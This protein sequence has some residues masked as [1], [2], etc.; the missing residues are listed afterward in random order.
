MAWLPQSKLLPLQVLLICLLGVLEYKRSRYL[1]IAI[2]FYFIYRLIDLVLLFPS[3]L[4][5]LQWHT[6]TLC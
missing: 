1:I 5:L 4:L 2:V 6:R 3:V